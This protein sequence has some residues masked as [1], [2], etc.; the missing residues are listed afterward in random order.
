MVPTSRDPECLRTYEFGFELGLPILKEHR[1]DFQEVR[2]EF[3][4]RRALG[5]RAWPSR[6]IADEEPGVGVLLHDG[7]EVAHA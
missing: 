4:E 7:G 1:D 5:V 6:D 3:I 2:S